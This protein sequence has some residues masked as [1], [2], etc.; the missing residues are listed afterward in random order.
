MHVS[1]VILTFPPTSLA[2]FENRG[3][4]LVRSGEPGYS[5]IAAQ[6]QPALATEAIEQARPILAEA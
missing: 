2:V 1:C 6:N 4:N 3:T 5:L